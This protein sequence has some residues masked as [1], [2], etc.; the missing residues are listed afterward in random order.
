MLK[1]WMINTNCNNMKIKLMSKKRPLGQK[2]GWGLNLSGLKKGSEP[3]LSDYEPAI[4]VHFLHSVAAP[5]LQPNFFLWQRKRKENRSFPF[6]IEGFSVW[7]DNDTKKHHLHQF[8]WVQHLAKK[9]HHILQNEWSSLRKK[10]EGCK[11]DIWGIDPTQQYPSQALPKAQ[12][13]QEQSAKI[14]V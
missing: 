8:D 13:T 1:G 7:V 11:E 12:R 4:Q 5:A 6:C 9:I 10:E 2:V 3:C 14:T